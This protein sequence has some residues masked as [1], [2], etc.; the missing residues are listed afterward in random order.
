M[1]KITQEELLEIFRELKKLLKP[2][3]RG[4][5]K[6]RMDI[7]G[8]YDLWSE[9]AGITIAGRQRDDLAFCTL[10]VQSGY[11]GFYYMPVYCEETLKETLHP[12][13][14]RTLKGKACFHIKSKEEPVLR[15]V[16]EALKKGY[17]LY[18]ENGW[19]S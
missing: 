9:K 7:E 11:V 1:A 12:D 4:S 10:I 6:A 13:L 2:Y 8:K 5:V 18:H 16:A 3:E 15:Q 17:E 19:I 14:L